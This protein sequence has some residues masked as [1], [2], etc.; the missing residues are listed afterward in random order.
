MVI[1]VQQDKGGLDRVRTKST[2]F[3]CCL[4]KVLDLL[5]QLIKQRWYRS[6]ADFF[7]RKYNLILQ[8]DFF[9]FFLCNLDS[10]DYLENFVEIFAFI[11]Y[12]VGNILTSLH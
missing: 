6:Q 12:S 5:L 4:R 8:F 7:S 10:F 9:I 2:L 3:D 1:A 11:A